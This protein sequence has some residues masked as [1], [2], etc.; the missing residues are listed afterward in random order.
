MRI[1]ASDLQAWPVCSHEGVIGVI[2]RN[3]IES[4]ASNGDAEKPLGEIIE[5]GEFPHVHT[6]HS[7]HSALDRMGA[8]GLEAL[9]VV[10]RANVHQ[11]MGIVTLDDVLAQYRVRNKENE[12][13][14]TE[15]LNS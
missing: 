13:S 6:D 5:T 12:V 4:A 11:L 7:L 10:S 14:Q 1:A 3:A 15:S 9:P 8:A 2:G